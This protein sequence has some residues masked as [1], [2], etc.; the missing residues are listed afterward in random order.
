MCTHTRPN[1]TVHNGLKK[2]QQKK[3]SK[4][5]A[6][7]Y[8]N[9]KAIK[10]WHKRFKGSPPC[11]RLP[12]CLYLHEI[13]WSGG[14]IWEIGFRFSRLKIQTAALVTS[15]VFLQTSTSSPF[16]S[17]PSV[18]EQAKGQSQNLH[19][20]HRLSVF[21]CAQQHTASLLCIT[22]LGSDLYRRVDRRRGKMWVKKL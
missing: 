1:P 3:E 4:E 6:K 8:R 10:S 11:C 22:K 15:V 13:E 7:Y 9:N 5:W 12:F 19:K 16:K 2:K 14:E 17:I 21:S 20:A 18:C